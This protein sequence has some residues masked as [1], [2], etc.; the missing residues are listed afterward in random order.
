MELI[1]LEMLP[2]ASEE[3]DTR[4]GICFSFREVRF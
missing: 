4:I 1:I 2:R 3:I